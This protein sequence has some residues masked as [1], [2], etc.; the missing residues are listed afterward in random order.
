[1]VKQARILVVEDEEN[2]RL[3][4]SEEL[5][6]SGYIVETAANAEEAL[7]KLDKNRFDLAT[8][9]VEMPGMNG[10]ELAGLLRQK[11]PG[12]KI[13]LLTAY[14]HYKYDL[15]SWAAD[16]YI[17]KSADLEELKRTIAKLMSM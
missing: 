15:A 5:Q 12:I 16:A 9:D 13:V 3:L 17:V 11:F 10:I 2:V 7:K 14:S 4:I 8:I 6:D 1:M